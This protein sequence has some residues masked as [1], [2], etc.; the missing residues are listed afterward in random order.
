MSRASRARRVAAAAAFGGGGLAGLGAAGVGVLLAEAKVARRQIGTPF[1]LQGPDCGGL[2]GAGAGEPVQMAMFGDSSAAG[3]GVERPEEA[4]GAVIAS[5]LAALTGRPVR[6]HQLAEVGAETRQLDGQVDRF[7][8]ATS[9]PSVAVI[10]IGANDVTHRIKPAESVRS[11][12]AAVT[13]LRE[14]GAVVVVG[15]CPDLGTIE[16]IPQ[17]LRWLAR[18]WSREMAAAQTIGVVEAGGRTVSL[19]DLLGE[20]FATRPQVMFSADGFHPSGAGYARAAAA[21]LPSVCA[22]LG[23]LPAG[24]DRIPDLRL[25]EGVDDVA[26]AAAR[27][28]AVPGT[29]VTATE[30]AGAARGPR[31][32]W[33]VLLHRVRAP[34][35]ALP[36]VGRREDGTPPEDGAHE[37]LAEA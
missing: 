23:V 21:L 5:G 24:E 34:L 16:P 32:R 20:E 7:L 10:M 15:T 33:A 8:A 37:N 2:Y 14:A 3:L 25:G 18:R 19:G 9:T 1:G 31:G 35:P 12:A 4:P 11:L 27:A 26:H 30:V 13:R 22:A 29:E 17:P 28:V 6:L 36:R